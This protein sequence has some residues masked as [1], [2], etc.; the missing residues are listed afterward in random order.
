VT[1]RLSLLLC[2][3]GPLLESAAKPPYGKEPLVLGVAHDWYVV[4]GALIAAAILVALRLPAIPVPLGTRMGQSSWDFTK[5]W[6]SNLTTAG[7]FLTTILG[8]GITPK[9]SPPST[10]PTKPLSQTTHLMNDYVAM[11][12]FFVLLAIVAAVAYGATASPVEV[13]TPNGKATQRQGRVASFLVAS[14]LTLWSVFGQIIT[15]LLV[16][17]VIQGQEDLSTISTGVFWVIL[18]AALG[19]IAVY[20]WRTIPWTVEE[21]ASAKARE[22]HQTR[23][24][25]EMREKGMEPPPVEDLEPPLPSWSLL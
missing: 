5:S 14:G 16:F 9:S 6:A 20:A 12:L 8:A 22:R 10:D 2:S 17:R 23:V 7:A 3:A 13:D 25:T 1:S 15:V 11:S 4:I 18:I 21:Q 24:A 19:C